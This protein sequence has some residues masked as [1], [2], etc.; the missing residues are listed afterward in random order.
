[1]QIYGIYVLY[2]NIQICLELNRCTI[3]YGE[4]Y[5]WVVVFFQRFSFTAN[6]GSGVLFAEKEWPLTALAR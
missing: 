5:C 6:V 2:R 1:M 3:I 4:K